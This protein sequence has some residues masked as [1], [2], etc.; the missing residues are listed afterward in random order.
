[1]NG[2]FK[3]L[4]EA[5]RETAIWHEAD[6]VVVG[7]GPGGHSAAVAA[8]R[9]GAKTVLVERYGHL[10]G[11]ATG[12]LVI[13]L[14]MMSDG[15]E[16]Q[17]IGGI[18]QEWIDRLDKVGQVV[19]PQKTELGSSE[20][21]AVDRWK[22]IVFGVVGGTVRLQ[23]MLEPEWLK[24][25]LNEMAEEAGVKLML[26][27]WGTQAIVEE[28]RVKGVIFESKSGRNA[29]LGKII[30]DATG[31]GDIMT[32]SGAA[33]DSNVDYSLRAS[34][35]ALVWRFGGCDFKKYCAFKKNHPQE[36]LKLEAE[37]KNDTMGIRIQPLVSTRNDVLW[38]NNWI[39]N[40]D[41]TNV[42]HLTNVEIEMRKMMLK[43]YHFYKKNI[44]GF[45][46]CFIYDTASQVGTRGGRRLK[47]EYMLS[48]E[49]MLTGK[50]H[51]DTIAVFPNTV[52]SP[53][54]ALPPEYSNRVYVPYRCMLPK[55]IEGFM[56]ACRAFSSD[57]P[58]NNAFNWIPHTIALGEAA[59]TAAAIAVKEGVEPRNVDVSLLQR[60]L[61][62]Q[63]VLLPDV[64]IRE[65]E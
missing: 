38:F 24:I 31:D 42:E 20:K 25:I 10:G 1:M 60:Q 40:R 18:C 2:Q 36:H 46:D 11:M 22:D 32:S 4:T 50:I 63:G 43:T 6:V 39:P 21:E 64:Q 33:Y 13:Q 34:N 5:E 51:E 3:T 57:T 35:L 45:E 55:E 28:G 59:G 61:L 7:G 53:R 48:L 47:G 30:I 19:Y 37:L 54:E 52:G 23:A 56:V 27:S 8:A 9:N 17:Q 15:T 65:S 12:G 16:E 49:D 14:L 62:K 41:Q 26:H 29:L 58:A 44:P